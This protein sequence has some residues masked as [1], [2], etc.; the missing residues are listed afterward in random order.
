MEIC[1]RVLNETSNADAKL[2]NILSSL[3]LFSKFAEKKQGLKRASGWFQNPV[4]VEDVENFRL[5]VIR[6]TEMFPASLEIGF[7]VLSAMDRLYDAREM[8]EVLDRWGLVL[9]KV[10]NRSNLNMV[11][12]DSG[13]LYTNISGNMVGDLLYIYTANDFP[14]PELLR[15]VCQHILNKDKPLLYSI[16]NAN[17]SKNIAVLHIFHSLA[18]LT[19]QLDAHADVEAALK[20]VSGELERYVP[21]WGFYELWGVGEI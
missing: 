8:R 16:D 1:K 18:T 2:E 6:R 19:R 21:Q 12:E 3:V 9:A 4:V 17:T 10:I 20:Y 11:D 13:A 14:H 15:A 7:L 5:E